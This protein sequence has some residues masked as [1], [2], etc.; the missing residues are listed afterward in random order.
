MTQ[1]FFDALSRN[2]PAG[3][4]DTFT[5]LLATMCSMVPRLGCV[6]LGWV[7]GHRDAQPLAASE[8]TFAGNVPRNHPEFK[9]SK[10]DMVA[11]SLDA[12]VEVW[13][14]HKLA[15]KEGPPVPGGMVYQI[16]K[17]V[18]TAR[19]YVKQEG[20]SCQTVVVVYCTRDRDA[21]RDRGLLPTACDSPVS[22]VDGCHG[23]LRWWQLLELIESDDAQVRQGVAAEDLRLLDGF[24]AY[25][26]SMRGMWS[27]A[28]S[29]EWAPS[30]EARSDPS[31]GIRLDAVWRPTVAELHRRF[32]VGHPR[33]SHGESKGNGWYHKELQH[34]YLT[35][36]QIYRAVGS[37]FPNWPV[38]DVGEALCLRLTLTNGWL[39]HR[40]RKDIIEA[41]YGRA[42]VDWTTNNQGP[43]CKV[44]IPVGDW[45]PGLSMDA[46]GDL[47]RR[48]WTPLIDEI[49]TR[50][51]GG[52]S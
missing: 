6:V 46:E 51:G 52:S 37:D 11:T 48:T 10:I 44:G 3:E 18:E 47:I 9:G 35:M 30:A 15:S 7:D 31:V 12:Q 1:R 19:H 42:S 13:F 16:H 4:E 25:W 2:L 38:A 43:V 49:L 21:I 40:L 26:R 50:L 14:E 22:L 27:A 17:Y 34:D 20:N 5:A 45:E 36:V 29:E 28:T 24:L 32:P 8:F 39:T 23:S 41:L 33:S